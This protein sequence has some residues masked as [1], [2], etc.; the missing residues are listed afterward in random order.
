M[1]IAKLRRTGNSVVV[2]IPPEELER[3][4]LVVGQQ[5]AVEVQPVT[6]RPALRPELAALMPELLAQHAEALRYL[7]DK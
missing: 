7:A 1:I 3:L 2:T 6:V 5:V 4:G